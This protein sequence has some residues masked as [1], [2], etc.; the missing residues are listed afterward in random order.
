V[1][2]VEATAFEQSILLYP[3]SD[4][5]VWRGLIGVDLDVEVRE[6]FVSVTVITAEDTPMH[7]RYPLTVVSKQFA[8]RQ[9]TVEPQYVNPTPEALARIQQEAARTTTIFETQ[10]PQRVW[11]GSFLAPVP[12]KATSSFGRRSVFNG[13]PRSPHS[14]ADFRAIEGTP[15]TAPNRGR[16][17][18]RS[19]LYFSGNCVIL[20][21]G[22]GLYS[23]FAHLSGFAV[24]EG[25]LVDSGDVVGYV[26]ATGRVTGPHL[27]WTVR[28]NTARV[29][30][31]S[32]M[33]VLF[34]DS[35]TY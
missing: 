34:D 33:E 21:H 10:T 17:V 28:L 35:A 4:Q 1:V 11:R 18:L 27:H 31:L 16:V 20:D 24:E 2:S 30:P 6:H 3:S 29:D 23:F 25:D 19:D 5:M 22:L 8:T 7:V 15:V 26:G 13:Q 14:G 12:G 9:L 32:L